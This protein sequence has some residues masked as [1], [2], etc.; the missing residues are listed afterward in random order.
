MPRRG[1]TAAADSSTPKVWP[2][3]GTG[4]FGSLIDTWASNDIA[5]ATPMTTAMSRTRLL[6]NRSA[7]TGRRKAK[8]DCPYAGTEVVTCG[9]FGRRGKGRAAVGGATIAC[10]PTGDQLPSRQWN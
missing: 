5:A 6:G 1:P 10:E 2:V 7:S 8:L 4:L 9:P 3:T